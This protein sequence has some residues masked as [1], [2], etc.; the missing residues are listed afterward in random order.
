MDS[1]SLSVPDRRGF[2]RYRVFASSACNKKHSFRVLFSTLRL[3]GRHHGY[4]NVCGGHVL[5]QRNSAS[6]GLCLFQSIT[7]IVSAFGPALGGLVAD[8]FGSYP[9]AFYMAGIFVALSAAVIFLVLFV[10][11]DQEDNEQEETTITETLII[12]E[13]CTVV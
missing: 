4:C 2:G 8:S 3:H 12:V 10:K 11:Q 1:S 6:P 9:P 13:K 5:F 7:N